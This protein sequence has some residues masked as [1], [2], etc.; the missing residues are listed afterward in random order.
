[1]NKKITKG[2]TNNTWITIGI[3]VSCMHKEYLYLINRNND[4]PN[5]KKYYKQYCKILANVIKQAKK[6]MYANQITNSTNKV[7]AA[8]DI[9]K[10]ETNR[11]HRPSANRYQ[12]SPDAFNNY[13]LSIAN[14]IICAT[15]QKNSKDSKTYESPPH[16]LTN[17]FHKPFPNIQF[18]NTSTNEINK[19]I[20]SLHLKKSSGYEEIS[21]KIMKISAP[22]Y[23]FSSK[24]YLQ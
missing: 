2:S 20:K 1:L 11:I 23:L 6:S 3:K 10:A 21:T 7:K 12:N 18:N 9:I 24:L 4:D 14:K 17:L 16:Y 5:L 15:R 19:I 13:F 22:F 8:W